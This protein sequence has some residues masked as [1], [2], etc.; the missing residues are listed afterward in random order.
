MTQIIDCR[1]Y[2]NNSPCLW[3]NLEK[4]SEESQLYNLERRNLKKL[5]NNEILKHSQLF[6]AD[7]SDIKVKSTVPNTQHNRIND[8]DSLKTFEI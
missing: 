5:K 8:R 3:K 2:E 4:G 1:I 6:H 7:I